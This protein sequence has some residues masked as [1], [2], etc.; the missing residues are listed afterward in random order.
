M[1][2]KEVTLQNKE[3]FMLIR[4]KEMDKKDLRVFNRLKRAPEDRKAHMAALSSI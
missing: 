4:I 3:H 2:L 1:F